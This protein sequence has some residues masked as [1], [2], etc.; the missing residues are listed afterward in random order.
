[1][2]ENSG[3]APRALLAKKRFGQHFLTDKNLL[4]KIVNTAGVGQGGRVLE[5]GPGPG[6]LTAELINAGAFVTAIEIDTGLCAALRERFRGSPQFELISAD[7]L[8]TSFTALAKERGCVFKAVS[9]LP[10]NITGPLIFKFISERDAFASMTLMLQKE[11]AERLASPPGTKEYGGPSVMCQAYFDVSLEFTVS[12]NLFTPKPKVDSCVVGFKVLPSPKARITD[13]AFFAKTVKAGFS[14]RR[15]TLSNALR[16]LGFAPDGVLKA[17][18][19]AA[20]DPK[21]RAE[22]LTVDEFAALSTAFLE[23]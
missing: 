6:A 4:K 1:M 9:N 3:N 23:P 12:K 21:R 17:L 19:K 14:Q 8:K 11:V 5:I 15:K 22:T 13:E 16:T 7:V 2:P 10:Y 20:I 18:H